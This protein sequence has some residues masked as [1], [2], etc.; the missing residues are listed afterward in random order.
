M[1]RTFRFL[2]CLV[3]AATLPACATDPPAKESADTWN[4]GILVMDGVYNTEL[5]GPYDIFSH[6]DPFR[7]FTV[8]PDR[9]ELLTAEGIRFQPDFGFDDHPPIEILV[10]PSFEDYAAHIEQEPLLGWIRDRANDAEWVLSHCWGAFYLAAAGLLDGR[11]AMT[12]PPDLDQF[13]AMFPAVEVKTGYRFVRDGKFITS[14]G[15]V[16]SYESPLFLLR[17]LAGDEWAE[18]V[19]RGLVIPD[20]RQDTIDYLER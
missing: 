20:W 12:Y 19:A 5:V 3:L 2:S 15:G 1:A 14:A 17:H 16:A 4:V 7:V 10:I 18:R 13:A 9:K 8:A 6:A 11:Q